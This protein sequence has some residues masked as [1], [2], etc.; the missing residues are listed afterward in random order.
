MGMPPGKCFPKD[1]RREKLILDKRMVSPILSLD[2]MTYTLYSDKEPRVAE[3]A[4]V[5]LN[6]YDKVSNPVSGK[7]I[8]LQ[9]TKI[10]NCLTL[11]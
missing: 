3:I 4:K 10:P 1:I 11:G 7:S 2:W 9:I 6:E 5:D 8:N